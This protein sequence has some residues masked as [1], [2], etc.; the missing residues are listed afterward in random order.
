MKEDILEQ[1]LE[2]W[3]ISKEGWFVKHNVKFRPDSKHKQYDSKKDSVHSDIDLLGLS[4]RERGINKVI[5]VT[6]KSWQGGFNLGKWLRVFDEKPIYN[7]RNEKFTPREKWKYFRELTSDKWIKAFLDKIENETGQ[8]K[9]IYYIAVTRLSN[10]KLDYRNLETP[11]KISKR[12][13]KHNG[14]IV[15]RVITLED[16]LKDYSDRITHKA[17]TSLESSEVGRLLQLINASGLKI[18]TKNKNA[19]DK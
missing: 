16:I 15:L 5:V 6:C 13:Q 2:D 11:I 3:I 18:T 10:H 4:N 1:L 14:Q 17:T 19:A 9:L 8:R 12:F 7:E